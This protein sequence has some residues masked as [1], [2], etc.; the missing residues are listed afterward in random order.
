MILTNLK[1]MIVYRAVEPAIVDVGH[2]FTKHPF[3]EKMMPQSYQ[4]GIDRRGAVIKYEY[5]NWVDLILIFHNHL[6]VGRQS[7][8]M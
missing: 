3:A 5:C 2:H 4:Y 1:F 7:R 6:G 8:S